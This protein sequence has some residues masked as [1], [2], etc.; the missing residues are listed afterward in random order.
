MTLV[1]EKKPPTQ[2]DVNYGYIARGSVPE[3]VAFV[4]TPPINRDVTGIRLGF[5]SAQ[6]IQPVTFEFP[7]FH[8]KQ[9]QEIATLLSGWLPL[10]DDKRLRRA[11]HQNL[12]DELPPLTDPSSN[13]T[14]EMTIISRQLEERSAAYLTGDEKILAWCY[15]PAWLPGAK[16]AR[17]LL[18]TTTRMMIISASGG[19][20][21]VLAV[22]LQE[23]ASLEYCSTYMDAHL[24]VFL[25]Q[26]D[27]I[28]SETIR[29]SKTLAAMEHCYHTLLQALA[30]VP[31]EQPLDC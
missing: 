28:R 1:E 12:S 18:I 13:N 7:A 2:S 5:R 29:F 11:A 16:E 27:E 17:V 10:P 26:K 15:L 4:E 14:Q 24:T 9:L 21:P 3:R 20:S 23:I 22:G 8:E 6:G 25:P 19:E 30:Y 31:F